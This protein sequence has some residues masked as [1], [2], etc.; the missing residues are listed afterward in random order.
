MQMEGVLCVFL[1]LKLNLMAATLY[2]QQPRF[3]FPKVWVND[4]MLWILIDLYFS[5][6]F[7]YLMVSI[8]TFCI[9]VPKVCLSKTKHHMAA[10]YNSHTN[11]LI[12]QFYQ[13][14]KQRKTDKLRRKEK[15][16]LSIQ[17]TLAHC[18]S[19]TLILDCFVQLRRGIRE[20]SVLACICLSDRL[21]WA[22]FPPS[23]TAAWSP[24]QCFRR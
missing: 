13:M 1:K 16:S 24:K 23:L 4:P 15:L 5:T 20:F 6:P 2:L 14:N 8:I 19:P 18:S 11:S 21:E 12:C 10:L 22:G 9:C 3:F 17:L 7:H